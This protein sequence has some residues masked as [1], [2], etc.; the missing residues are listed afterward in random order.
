VLVA[1]LNMPAPENSASWYSSEELHMPIE[2]EDISYRPEWSVVSLTKVRCLV[3]W[4]DT[5][6]TL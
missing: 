2:M 4:K 6:I 1:D 3:D 5:V